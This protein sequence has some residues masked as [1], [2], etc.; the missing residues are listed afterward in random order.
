MSN[1]PLDKNKP[2]NKPDVQFTT[3]NIGRWASRQEDPFAK[4][5]RQEQEKKNARAKKR[6][7]ASP[8]IVL[9]ISIPLVGAAIFGLV[10]L[11]INIVNRPAPVAPPTIAGNSTQDISDYRDI[12]QGIFDRNKGT[13]EEKR[14]EIDQA[15]EGTLG[16]SA[17]KE[18]DSSVRLAQGSFYLNNNMANEAISSVENLNP[19]HLNLEQKQVY[20]YVLYYANALNGNTKKAQEYSNILF[21][22]TYELVEGEANNEN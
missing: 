19:D 5:K 10:M 8:I 22:I 1:S 11:I 2:D 15:V 17:G 7:K 13:N 18:Y 21:D 4:Q 12:L 9:I 16:T 3:E 14:Q 6:Q 20:Y